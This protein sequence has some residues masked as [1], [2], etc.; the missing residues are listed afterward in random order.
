LVGVDEINGFYLIE[1]NRLAFSFI[2]QF[3]KLTIEGG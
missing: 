3:E 1:A 2:D